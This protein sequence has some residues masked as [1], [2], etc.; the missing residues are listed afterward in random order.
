MP[1][2]GSNGNFY[3][4]NRNYASN[5][6]LELEYNHEDDTLHGYENGIEKYFLSRIQVPDYKNKKVIVYETA[7]YSGG[8]RI[9]HAGIPLS[10]YSHN[11]ILNA[12]GIYDYS[13]APRTIIEEDGFIVVRAQHWTPEYYGIQSRLFISIIRDG[14]VINV[15]DSEYYGNSVLT[16]SDVFPV[17]KDDTLVYSVGSEGEKPP[18]VYEIDFAPLYKE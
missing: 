7:L 18:N 6:S 15:F 14:N 11:W 13:Q 3:V 10:S 5:I 8:P 12:N 1:S 16:N 4:K 2:A 17:R 9:V